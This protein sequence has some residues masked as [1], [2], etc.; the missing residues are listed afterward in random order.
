MGWTGYPNARTRSEALAAHFD[1][2]KMLAKAVD[3]TDGR[4]WIVAEAQMPEGPRPLIVCVLVDGTMV[5]DVDESMG[6]VYYDC[7]LSF[8][9]MAPQAPGPFAAEWRAKV[10]EFWG[11]RR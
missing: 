10:R 6:P 3:R 8:L 2:V 1:D 4:V 9:D 11:V 5:K 7:P